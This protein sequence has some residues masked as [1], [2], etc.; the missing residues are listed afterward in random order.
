MV[1]GPQC[2]MEKIRNFYFINGSEP[3]DCR[4][5]WKDFCKL[6]ANWTS[7]ESLISWLLQEV[8]GSSTM[9][10]YWFS[11]KHLYIKMTDS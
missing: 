11:R 10:F 6:S 2:A 1:F 8:P 7:L 9:G 3:E 5:M 4:Y